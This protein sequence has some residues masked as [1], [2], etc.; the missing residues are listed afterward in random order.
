MPPDSSGRI[1]EVVVVTEELLTRNEVAR[2]LKKPESW[3]K[4]AERHRLLQYVKVGQQIRY[5][6]SDVENYIAA[7]LVP[8]GSENK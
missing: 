3:L 2:L 1:R 6:R 4:Y 8:P 5:R 7:H